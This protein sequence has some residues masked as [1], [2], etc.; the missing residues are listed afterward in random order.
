MASV[1]GVDV[2]RGGP[3]PSAFGRALTRALSL[4]IALSVLLLAAFLGQVVYLLGVVSWVDHS[5][6]VIA[7]AYLL[8][9]LLLDMETGVRGYLVVGD[10]L[11]LQPYEAAARA[12]DAEFAALGEQVGD[13][14]GQ[15]A[16]VGELRAS[17]ESWAAHA[18]A[19]IGLRERGSPEAS[20]K[21][22]NAR[23]KRIMDGIRGRIDAFTGVEE[24]L[25]DRRVA[26]ARVA[27]WGVIGGSAAVAVF[28]GA[29]I[30][31]HARRR[32]VDLSRSYAEAS[33]SAR[34]R[35]EAAARH[36]RRLETLHET[37]RAILRADSSA[38]IGRRS[39]ETIRRSVRWPLLDIV[40]FDKAAGRAE[41]LASLSEGG[42]GLNLGESVPL[43]DFIDLE[44][45]RA[46]GGPIVDDLSRPEGLRP[47]AARHRAEGVTSI[48]RFPMMAQ[49]RLVGTLNLGGFGP[50]GL[51]R[52]DAEVAEELAAQIAIAIE[53]SRLRDQLRRQ[54]EGLE[55]TVE[56]R[57]R[58]LLDA[59]ADLEAFS[60]SVAHDLRAPLRG[61][62]GLAQA[63]LEDYG[64]RLDETGQDYAR[65][66][67]AAARR[68]DTLIQ[69]LLAYGR[70]GRSEVRPSPVP[71]DTVVDEALLMLEADASDLATI[72]EVNRPMP[73]VMAHRL[74]LSQ[75][76]ANLIGNAIKFHRPGE[77]PRVRIFAERREGGRVR[78]WV[79]DEGL[80]I[81]AEHL[82][83]IF[84]IFERLHGAETYPGTGIGLAIVRR[85]V[86]RMGG[87][88]GVE[89]TTGVGSRFWVELPEARDSQ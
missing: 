44:R 40:L 83:R 9:K 67:V 79:E 3:K 58:Q 38:E 35:A 60:Y 1:T 28:V 53:Q 5:D 61:M 16:A 71:L 15:A 42:V 76:V 64:D 75:A 56:A 41:V 50:G 21:E 51:P 47:V 62:Q 6:R 33:E 65:R 88:V 20:E 39:L 48:T 31:A 18:R 84:R 36:A 78:F 72:V 4:P 25:R 8:Q 85:G 66:V 69:D 37:D 81:E 7:R 82:D 46:A 43:A 19:M 59:V 54:A 26:T 68:M 29:G 23:G 49:G 17:Y 80:G 10:R 87:A 86:E 73:E 74:T 30:A 13:N 11:F 63:L 89:S 2:M 12:V 57:T 55:A 52:E 77:V 22:A 45:V 32:L 24:R 27:T 70:L 14:P 34:E